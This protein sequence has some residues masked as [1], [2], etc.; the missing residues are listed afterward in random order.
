[1]LCNYCCQITHDTTFFLE[2]YCNV[3]VARVTFVETRSSIVV[4]ERIP[5]IPAVPHLPQV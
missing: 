4:I 1:M 5:P 3:V 2:L